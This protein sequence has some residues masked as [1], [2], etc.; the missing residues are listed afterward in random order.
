MR[1]NSSYFHSLNGR[2]RIK[3]VE[4]KGAPDK[5]GKLKKQLL[6]LNGIKY[7]KANPTTG[8]VLILYDH[9]LIGEADIISTLQALGYLA[10]S[11]GRQ[12]PMMRSKA[13]IQSALAGEIPK[14][15]VQNLVCT[16][17]KIAFQKLVISLI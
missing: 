4:V 6:R 3:I 13:E 7:L 8:N 15:L 5:A 10:E 2:M 11:R 14:R 12:I 9:N 16:M 17:V 1:V